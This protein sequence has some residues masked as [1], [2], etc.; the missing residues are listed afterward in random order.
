MSPTGSAT[1][2]K[3]P[4]DCDGDS[5][6]TIDELIRGVN[7]ALGNAHVED[8]LNMDRSGDGKVTI[9]ELIAAV[10]ASLNGCP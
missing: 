4:G 8:C 3:C 7:I 1:P 6:V 9:D 2:R 5:F 10:G